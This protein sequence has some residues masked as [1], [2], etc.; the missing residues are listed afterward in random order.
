MKRILHYFIICLI[1]A[2]SYAQPIVIGTAP[3]NPPLSFQTSSV[4]NFSGFEVDLMQRLCNRIPLTCEYRSVVVSQI[5]PELQAGHL[6]FAIAGLVI[7]TQPPDGVLFSLPY[8][9]SGVQFLTMADSKIKAPDDIRGKTVGIRKGSLGGG[10][11]FR[12][13]VL[14]LYE[15]EVTVKYYY[16]MNHLI[17]GLTNHEVDVVFSNELGIKYWYYNNRQRYRLIGSEV[18]YGNGYG[19]LTTSRNS[20]LLK[21]LNHELLETIADGTYLQVYNQYFSQIL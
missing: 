6:D 7:P 13:F 5:L 20:E 2:K 12:N 1:I 10:Q 21:Q 11:L 19:I 15:N 3:D 4:T 16:S 14:Q 17:L 8:L 18:P 9:Q